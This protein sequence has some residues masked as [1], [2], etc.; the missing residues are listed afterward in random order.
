LSFP[1]SESSSP[2]VVVVAA[3][4]SCASFPSRRF[5][6]NDNTTRCDLSAPSSAFPAISK[7]KSYIFLFFSSEKKFA[8]KN[9][10]QETKP[11]L[12]SKH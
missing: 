9:F 2:A 5:D 4:A 8:V 11:W 3:G 12:A 1:R 6:Y 7:E 10:D